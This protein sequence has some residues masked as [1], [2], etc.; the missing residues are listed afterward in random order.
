MNEGGRG[1]R[2]RG[3]EGVNEGEEEEEGGS[4]GGSRFQF[5]AIPTPNHRPT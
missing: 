1:E 5:Y 4:E 2:E 3:R